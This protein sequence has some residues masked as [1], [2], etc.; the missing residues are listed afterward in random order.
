[1]YIYLCYSLDIFCNEDLVVF[2]IM[3][4]HEHGR[5]VSCRS[6]KYTR[7]HTSVYYVGT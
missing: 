6:N 3:H 4:K 2:V 5:F 1:M 7:R